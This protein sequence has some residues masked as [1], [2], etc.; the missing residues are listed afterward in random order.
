MILGVLECV[1]VEPPL[2]GVKLVAK[3]EPNLDQGKWKEPK[4]PVG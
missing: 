3:F 4:P 1:E 2:G